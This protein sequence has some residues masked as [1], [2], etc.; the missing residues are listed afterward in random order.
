MRKNADGTTSFEVGGLKYFTPP[1]THRRSVD[2]SE[3]NNPFNVLA[4]CNFDN[5]SGCLDVTQVSQIHVN[6]SQQAE[7]SSHFSSPKSSITSGFVM[8][9]NVS[10]SRDYESNSKKKSSN[11]RAKYAS[12]K[13]A[14]DFCRADLFIWRKEFADG[15]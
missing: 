9:V 1:T 4:A 13:R 11:D 6:V 12:Q 3:T 7:K 5:D 14:V 2:I 8:E 10:D 15:V